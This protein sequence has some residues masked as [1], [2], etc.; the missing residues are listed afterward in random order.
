MNSKPLIGNASL[1][2]ITNGLMH[3]SHWNPYG[4]RLQVIHEDERG[5]LQMATTGMSARD[6]NERA[7]LVFVI[8]IR[9]TEKVAF[10]SLTKTAICPSPE[11][12]KSIAYVVRMIDDIM[13][14]A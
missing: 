3:C 10:T 11:L 2:G 14:S 1:C 8:H 4:Y 12:T 6:V 7:L 5:V 13:C 9:S